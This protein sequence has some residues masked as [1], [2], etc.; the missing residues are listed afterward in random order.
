MPSPPTVR[1]P[2]NGAAP[3]REEGD[4]ARVRCPQTLKEQEREAER[5]ASENLNLKMRVQ[6][7]EEML[8]DRGDLE[9]SMNIWDL[10]SALSRERERIVE[11]AAKQVTER[12]DL[13]MRSHKVGSSSSVASV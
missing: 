4:A 2:E 3:S 11:E 7:L 1:S 8:G 9:E 10:R 6:H 13:L 5:M 12:D